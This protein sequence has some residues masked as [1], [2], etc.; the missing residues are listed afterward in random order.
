MVFMCKF[1]E[2]IVTVRLFE[3]STYS[4]LVQN[5]CAKWTDLKAGSISLSY[6]LPSHP[7][8]MLENGDDLL[9]SPE[10]IDR[11]DVIVRNYGRVGSVVICNKIVVVTDSDVGSSSCSGSKK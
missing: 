2:F 9:V 11:I 5:L 1:G 4:Q 3:N 8:C 10:N 6:S 7:Y